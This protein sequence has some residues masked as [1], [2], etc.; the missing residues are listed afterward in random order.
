[1]ETSCVGKLRSEKNV[2]GYLQH[3]PYLSSFNYLL[4]IISIVNDSQYNFMELFVVY[5]LKNH[6][7]GRKSGQFLTDDLIHKKNVPK[8]KLHF[9]I[10]L[11]F[12][13]FCK[14]AKSNYCVSLRPPVRPS[15][16]NNSAPTGRIFKKSDIS[17]FRKYVEKIQ[18]PLKSNKNKG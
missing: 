13:R 14:I 11:I 2:D 9:N 7:W 6:Q 16:R 15:A 1:M 12:R 18:V 8:T 10:I 3:L 17:I 4:I 5:F